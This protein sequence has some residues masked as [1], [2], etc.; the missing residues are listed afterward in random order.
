MKERREFVRV[1]T[2][3]YV[4]YKILDSSGKEGHCWS[5][6]ISVAGIGLFLKEKL[7]FGTMLE[8]RI[9][10]NDKFKPLISKAKVFWQSEAYELKESKEEY[11][12]TGIIFINL[13]ESDKSRVENFV[14]ANLKN[15]GK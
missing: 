6:D 14:N 1:Q 15:A 9:G 12:R 4:A 7:D 13:S 10:L 5:R 11:F 2:R 3:L 8:L